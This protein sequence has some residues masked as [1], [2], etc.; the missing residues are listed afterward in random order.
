MAKVKIEHL[1]K[2]FHETVAVDDVTLTV[3]D[4]DFVVLLGPSGCGKTT[5]LRMIAGLEVQTE[6]HIS[7][8][9]RIV[10]DLEPKERNVAM[11]FQSYALY[12]HLR[13]YENIAFGLRARREPRELIDRKVKEAAKIL[14]IDA[15][16]DRNPAALSGGQRQRVALARALVRNPD[17]FLLDEP[18]SNLDAKLR[19]ATR[20]ELKNLHKRLGRTMIYVTHDQ[21]E[22][23][24]LADKIAVM[25]SGRL[26][27]YGSPMNVFMKP[28]NRFVADFVGYPPMNMVEG[29]ITDSTE[30]P[31]FVAADLNIPV[32]GGRAGKYLMGIR[33]QDVKVL[34]TTAPGSVKCSVRGVER[35]GTE[36][37]VFLSSESS[38]LV[39][40][41]RMADFGS[42]DTVYALF[43]AQS[44]HFFDVETGQA[45]EF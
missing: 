20:I 2:R 16:L 40:T 32:T 23:M 43:D 17:V 41:V 11:V 19:A 12:P 30:G 36:N 38:D 26:L 31:A 6:G 5:T 15:L 29:D 44:V 10:D 21:V 8:G 35:T 42:G 7:I 22:A 24:T 1:T 34:K 4:G 18:L 45:V 25:N 28:Q 33:P 13:V 39:A 37:F 27:Q 14:Q 3:E 9:D